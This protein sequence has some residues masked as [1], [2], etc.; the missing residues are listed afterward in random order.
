MTT[1][2]CKNCEAELP[3]TY[4]SV[5]GEKRFDKHQLTIKHFAEETMEGMM[6]FDT[7]FLRNLKVLFTRPGL[8]SA[9]FLEG[10]QTRYMKPIAFF[11]VINLL[12][13]ML[14]IYGPFLPFAIQLYHLSAFYKL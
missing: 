6:H 3:Q 7:K 14:M 2:I 1:T 10:R 11:L 12:F 5:C 4:C 8:L 9:D 13:F